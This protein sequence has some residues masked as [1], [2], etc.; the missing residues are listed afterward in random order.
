MSYSQVIAFRDGKPAEVLECRNAW[1]GPAYIWTSLFDRYLKDPFIEYDSWLSRFSRNDNSLW[2]LVDREDIPAALRAVHYSTYD[3]AIIR[4]E[5]FQQFA[6]DLREF[7]ATFPTTGVC[8]L[9]AWAD[10][11]EKCDAEAIGFYGTSVSENLWFIDKEQTEADE[12]DED[13][14]PY[15][16]NTGDKHFEVYDR[17]RETAEAT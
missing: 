4:R 9:P 14:I 12:D 10:F 17:M 1:G 13:S 8:H 7:V 11:V 15:D 6:A 2:Q 3:R 5:H 16:L